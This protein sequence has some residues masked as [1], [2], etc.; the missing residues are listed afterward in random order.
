MIVCSA[1]EPDALLRCPAYPARDVETSARS[2]SVKAKLRPP[3]TERILS[4]RGQRVT[5]SAKPI[6]FVILCALRVRLP[7]LQIVKT[8][9]DLLNLGHELHQNSTRYSFHCFRWSHCAHCCAR[10]LQRSLALGPRSR[11]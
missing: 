4:Q 3:S 6:P 1:S 7:N 8:E 9:S 10:Q 5:T 2:P 11:N